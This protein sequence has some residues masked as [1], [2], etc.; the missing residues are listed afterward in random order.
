[1]ELRSRLRRVDSDYLVTKQFIKIKF[2]D[3]SITT[4]ERAVEKGLPL[5]S[6]ENICRQAWQRGARPVRLLGIG[7]RFI[8][9]GEPG[10]AIQLDLFDKS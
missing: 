2:N 10:R 7:V 9:A 1:M 3:F 8:D 4:L 5:E 6:F